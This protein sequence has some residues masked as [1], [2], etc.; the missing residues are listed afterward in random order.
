MRRG[1]HQHCGIPLSGLVTAVV[2]RL[3]QPVNATVRQ[4]DCILPG[5][6][7]EPGAVHL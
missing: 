3:C 2:N 5:E 1:K 6:Q 7:V 4:L